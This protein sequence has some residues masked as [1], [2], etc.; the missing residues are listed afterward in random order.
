MTKAF[1]NSTIVTIAHRI[2][3]IIDSDKILVMKDGKVAEFDKPKILL[4]NK[5]SL[6]Y[7][8]YM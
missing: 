7:S 2:N 4:K 6:F 3:T 8:L 1:K 5:R